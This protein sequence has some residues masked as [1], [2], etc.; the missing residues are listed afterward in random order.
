[1]TMIQLQTRAFGSPSRYIQG[2]CELENL[3]EY[4]DA[5]GKK[6]FILVDT[7]S[8]KN[9]KKSLKLCMQAATVP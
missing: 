9:I 2:R 1:M 7:F 5:Y 8:L 6:V 4:T 3:R